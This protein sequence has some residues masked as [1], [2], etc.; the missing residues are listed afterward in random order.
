LTSD[1]RAPLRPSNLALYAAVATAVLL[2]TLNGPI[3]KVGFRHFPPLLFFTLRIV[4]AGL[5]MNVV[6]LLRGVS[7]RSII[8]SDR[9]KLVALML[10]GHVG[11]QLGY[12]TGLSRTSVAHSSIIYAT[13]PITILSLAIL[14]GQEKLK[15]S[16]L[17]GMLISA[18]GVIILGFDQGSRIPGASPTFLGDLLTFGATM[19]FACVTV[20]G[21]AFRERYPAELFIGVAYTV[22][23][24]VAGPTLIW[25]GWDFDYAAV[26][27]EGWLS[28]LFMAVASA[29]GAYLLYFWALGY[30]AASTLANAQYLQPPIAVVIAAVFLAEPVTTALTIGGTVVLA[31]VYLAERRFQRL[32]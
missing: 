31:G 23:A 19:G 30:V 7:F 2:W 6:L 16:R 9:L 11:N 29:V 25:P 10:F 20:F 32:S 24:L 3:G 5:V 26:P 13:L 1:K 18:I 21:R 28:L 27:A 4:L 22:G 15:K 14:I 12:L 17:L 8:P